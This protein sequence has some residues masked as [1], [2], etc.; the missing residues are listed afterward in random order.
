MISHTNIERYSYLKK[1]G[2]TPK[3]TLDIGANNGDWANNFKTF[4]PS[5]EIL[6]IEGNPNL[7]LDLKHNNPNYKITLLGNEISTRKFYIRRSYD[8]CHGCSIYKENTPIYDDCIEAELPITTLDDLNT[9]N[10]KYEYIKIDVQGA[11]LDIIKGGLNTIS[12]CSFLDIELSVSRYNKGSPLLGD[13]V[14]YLNAIGFSMY[15][16]NG[17]FYCNEYLIQVNSIFVNTKIHSDYLDL[18]FP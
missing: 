13:V 11:E 12:Q 14:S 8:K 16:I 10:I 1:L 4:F 7:E 15:D 3:N 9:Q 18:H 5:T 17:L 6:S 2:F